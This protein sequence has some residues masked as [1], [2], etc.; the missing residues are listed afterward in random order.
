MSKD[1]L[2]TKESKRISPEIEQEKSHDTT[3][4]QS[5][6]AQCDSRHERIIQ[7]MEDLD[8]L[9]ETKDID[10]DSGVSSL[11]QSSDKVA[12]S[13]S[14]IT[15]TFDGEFDNETCHPTSNASVLETADFDRRPSDSSSITNFTHTMGSSEFRTSSV[16]SSRTSTITLPS[17][18]LSIRNKN[19]KLPATN[20]NTAETKEKHGVRTF[21]RKIFK[22]SSSYAPRNRTHSQTILNS[23][24]KGPVLNID[25]ERGTAYP[26][27]SP[28]PITQGPIRLL[29]LRHGERLDRYYSSQWLRQAFDKNGNFCRFSPILPET[30]PFRASIRDF[31]LDPPLTYKGLKDAFHT[32]T[33]LKEKGIHINYCYSSPALRCVQT[34]AK[35]LEGLQ[36]QNKLKMRIEPGIFECTGWYTADGNND[37]LT[38][39]RFMT[40]KEL[41]ENKY[42]IDKNYHEQMSMVD[43]SHLENELEFYQRCHAVTANILKMH[44]QEYINNI[45][46]GQTSPQQNVHILFVAHAPNLETCTRKLCGG[47]FRPDTLP[48]VIRNVDFLTM[49]VIEK[50]DN[51]CEKWIFRRSSFYGDEF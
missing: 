14:R 7:Q 3:N 43:L 46:Q 16:T 5:I 18:I 36:L 9:T 12:Q 25:E 34:A 45:Q 49:T 8:L 23:Q 11:R 48:H 38:M 4:T 1:D 32:G 28:L 37:T 39:P 51:N 24:Q 27:M 17:F 30:L 41:L 19:S 6:N 22:T 31:D 42:V 13:I 29:V 33:V 50:T 15:I 44:E 26:T 21:I 47:K 10:T 20:A 2:A 35:V 40:K